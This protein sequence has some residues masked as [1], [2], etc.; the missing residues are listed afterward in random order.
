MP[1]AIVTAGLFAVIS[2]IAIVPAHAA[3]LIFN[4]SFADGNTGFSSQYTE[5]SGTNSSWPENTYAIE[6]NPSHSHDLWINQ[7][8]GSDFLVVN[9]NTGTLKTVWEQDGL[10]TLAGKSYKFSI[11]VV[12]VCC[13]SAFS[14]SNNSPFDLHFNINTGKGFSTLETYSSGAPDQKPGQ[15]YTVTGFFT[16]GTK[17]GVQ[18]IDTSLAASGNDFAIGNISVSPVPEQSIW[19]SMILGLGLLGIAARR[20][21]SVLGGD[22]H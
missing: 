16:A 10:T 14:Q 12:D 11:D 15:V 3:N 7:N 8:L 2:A 9:G 18:I 6:N 22:S 20:R 21:G 17:L 13:T 1:R 19:A 5:V 4:G